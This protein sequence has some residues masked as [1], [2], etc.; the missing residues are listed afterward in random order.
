MKTEKTN[1]EDSAALLCYAVSLVKDGQ[2]YC[3]PQR[4]S[5]W[6]SAADFGE[7]E[8]FAGRATGFRVFTTEA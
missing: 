2:V 3:Q 1:N 5:D 7:Q 8:V 4:W 6:Q